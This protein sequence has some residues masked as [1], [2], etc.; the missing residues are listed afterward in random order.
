VSISA[1]TPTVNLDIDNYDTDSDVY[2]NDFTNAVS[3]EKITLGERYDNF[4]TGQS[5]EAYWDWIRIREYAST[6]PTVT[7]ED[8]EPLL[9]NLPVEITL[10]TNTFGYEK[11]GGVNGEDIRFLTSSGTPCDYWIETWDTSSTSTIWVELPLLSTGTTTA[12][13]MYYGNSGTSAGSN[14]SATFP[15]YDEFDDESVDA[16]WTWLNE[17]S[18]WDEGTTT[19]GRLRMVSEQNS[20]ACGNQENGQLLYQEFSGDFEIET[21]LYATPSQNTEQ[22]GIF[23]MQDVDDFFKVGYGYI[24]FIIGGR[25]PA[26]FTEVNNNCT[27]QANVLNSS[28]PKYFKVRRSG[29]SWQAW[30]HNEGTSVWTL[31]H[32]WTQT[33][34]DPLQVGVGVADGGDWPHSNHVVEYDYFDGQKL[35][36]SDPTVS[37]GQEESTTSW[38]DYFGSTTAISSSGTVTMSSGDINVDMDPNTI[39]IYPTS[40]YSINLPSVRGSATHYGA[41][42]DLAGASDGATTDVF[43]ANNTA[44]KNDLYGH[45]FDDDDYPSGDII[46]VKMYATLAL[47]GGSA[48]WVK[49]LFH[50]GTLHTGSAWYVSWNYATHNPYERDITSFRESWSWDDLRDG[51]FGVSMR[52]AFLNGAYCSQVYL[53]VTYSK[54]GD[55]TSDAITP[56]NLS[57]WGNFYG[58]HTLPSGTDITYKILDASDDSVLCTISGTQAAA[59]F[60]ISSCASS[61]SSIKLYAAPTTSDTDNNPTLHDWRVTWFPDN[62]PIVDVVGLYESDDSTPI[63]I[64]GSMDPQVEYAIK[65]TVADVDTLDDIN[66]VEITIFYDNSGTDSAAAGSSDTQTCAIITWTKS[67]SPAWTIDPSSSTTWSVETGNCGTPSISITEGNWWAHFKPG[68]VATE[69]GAADDWDIYAKATDASA[70][71]DDLYSRDYEMNWYGEITGVTSTFNFGSIDMGSTDTASTGAISATYISNGAYD[72]QTKSDASWTGQG[73]GATINLDTGGSPSS[74]EFSLKADD[75]NTLDSAIQ[76]LTTYVTIDDSGTQSVEAGVTQSNNYF[77]LTVGND[78]FPAEEYQGSVY[79][80]IADGS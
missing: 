2:D 23:V 49:P 68:K 12:V 40:D 1:G 76:V 20:D 67:G 69:S 47:F 31:L 52:G 71:N 3:T 79:F 9:T 16:K 29:N 38:M 14:K 43:I 10:T 42:D 36:S 24:W 6:E 70:N 22:S 57:S 75:D 27:L 64:G 55:V 35:A 62:S 5:Y 80:E 77:W 41:V 51:Y 4:G 26:V 58:S 25:G 53:E 32:S 45:N 33:L 39:I 74:A 19:A 48:S 34:T 63:G 59:G 7:L 11:V 44:W 66:E 61:A 60:N 46:Q 73:T 50:D 8:E 13:N 65:V 17:P 56:T 28:S 18:T 15:L 54:T 78:S 72:E 30:Y 21:K 37:L